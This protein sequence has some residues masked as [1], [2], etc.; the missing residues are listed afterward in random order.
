MKE[1]ERGERMEGKGD[2]NRTKTPGYTALTVYIHDQLLA[3]RL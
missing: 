3:D 1:R 2:P